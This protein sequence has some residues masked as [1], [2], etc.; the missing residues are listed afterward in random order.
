MIRA[1]RSD[2]FEASICNCNNLQLRQATN[3]AKEE[4][5]ATLK[6]ARDLLHEIIKCLELKG[7][8]FDIYKA[9]TEED[10]DEFWSVLLQVDATLPENNLTKKLYKPKQICVPS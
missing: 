1:K 6:P 5:S 10:M 7:C 2:E 9:A 8:A 3:T 4:V